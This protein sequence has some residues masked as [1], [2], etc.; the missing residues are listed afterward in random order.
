MSKR[1]ATSVEGPN[2]I[3]LR[4]HDEESLRSY[5][6]RKPDTHR[7]NDMLRRAELKEFLLMPSLAYDVSL[8]AEAVRLVALH[9]RELKIFDQA[10]HEVTGLPYDAPE[11]S[12]RP[13]QSHK[14][15]A[16]Q[17]CKQSTNFTSSG[18][19][20]E[21]LRDKT[22][23]RIAK[24]MAVK[25]F[26]LQRYTH[27]PT[28]L[29]RAIA[30]VAE[31]K[32]YN[33][34]GFVRNRMQTLLMKVAE[35][36]RQAS[37]FMPTVFTGLL[38]HQIQESQ[39]PLPRERPDILK[40]IAWVEVYGRGVI[41]ERNVDVMRQQLQEVVN[42]VTARIEGGSEKMEEVSVTDPS[43][44]Q[45][46]ELRQ[47]EEA[48][49][50]RRKKG[51]HQVPIPSLPNY[52]TNM[53]RLEWPGSIPD[54]FVNLEY[55]DRWKVFEEGLDKE[56][57]ELFNHEQWRPTFTANVINIL[58]SDLVRKIKDPEHGV[59]SERRRLKNKHLK[60]SRKSSLLKILEGLESLIPKLGTWILKHDRAQKEIYELKS[61][62]VAATQ[63]AQKAGREADEAHQQVVT[64]AEDLEFTEWKVE[65]LENL[66][67]KHRIKVPTFTREQ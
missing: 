29:M 35:A 9:P 10:I 15:I 8:V 4:E 12:D 23:R 26:C 59:S 36:P 51:V 34:C 56:E 61:K 48:E 55:N 66:L 14:V 58:V 6:R 28:H 21:G 52:L 41:S 7:C 39:L 3:E 53:L 50:R 60:L 67:R 5:L 63:L 30:G 27:F 62:A 44:G 32:K 22:V 17:Y 40:L 31:G 11:V 49:D 19:C 54:N 33:W 20:V 37:F 65:Q 57:C 43:H 38:F 64:M 45:R 47:V 1:L 42:R 24:L 46:I 16:E 13:K 18:I 25:L 2:Y